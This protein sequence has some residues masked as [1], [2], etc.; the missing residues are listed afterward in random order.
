MA[1]GSSSSE[2]QNYANWWTYYRTRMNMMTTSM[3]LAFKSVDSRYR[4][5]YSTISTFSAAEGTNF[6]SIRD[7]DATQKQ[8]FYARLAAAS[9]GGNTP[10][11]GALSK[12]G[13]YFAKKANGQIAADDPMQYSCQRNFTILSTDGYWN[14]GLERTTAPKYGPYQLDNNTLVAQQDGGATL[15]PMFD[16]GSVSSTTTEKWDR[17][18]VTV[19]RTDTPKSN[20]TTVV[21]STTVQKPASSTAGQ[22]Q[23]ISVL[24]PEFSPSSLSRN[25]TTITVTTSAAHGL[26]CGDVIDVAGGDGKSNSNRYLA[27]NATVTV[28][29]ATQF[30]YQVTTA[31][32]S[33][34]GG[35]YTISPGGIDCA[36]G[37]SVQRQQTFVRDTVTVTTTNVS[38]IT[39]VNSTSSFTTTETDTTPLTRTVKTVNGVVI[40]DTTT[41]GAVSSG[42]QNSSTTV[43]T[44]P[45]I[46]EHKLNTPPTTQTTTTTD[47]VLVTTGTAGATCSASPAATTTKSGLASTTTTQTT[48]RT[49]NTPSTING[50][51]VVTTISSTTTDGT[52][53]T[54]TPAPVTSGG[55]Q[56]TL[57]DIAMYYYQT[58]LRDTSLG[59]CTGALGSDVCNNNVPGGKGDAAH[60]F[61]DNATWQHM[62]T[63]TLGLGA[64]GMLKYDAAYQSQLSGDFFDITNSSKNWPTPQETDNGGGPQN[65]DDL[66]HAAVDG[67][68]Q[69]FSA[70]NPSSLAVSLNSA[71]DKI[72]SVTG[73]ASAA[74][75]SSLQPVQGDNDIY[76]AQFTT[77]KWVGDVLAFTIDPNDGSIST[78]P[79]WSA[80]TRLDLLAPASRVIYYADPKGAAPLHLFTFTNLTTDGYSSLFNNFCSDSNKRGA[81]GGTAPAQCANLNTANLALANSGTNLVNYLRGD[82]TQGYYRQ[83]DNLLGDIINA[84]PLFVGKPAFKYSENNYQT[85]AASNAGRQAVVL[86]A[87]NDGM[88]HAFKR[89]TGDELWAFIPSF[90]MG[91]LYKLADTGY[92]NNH[93]YFVDGSPILGD[94]YTGTAWK[95]IVVGGL[96]DGGRGYYAL[97]VTDP[98]A[99]KLLWEYKNDNLGLSYGNPIITKRKDGT[100]VVVIG[101]GYNNVSP[102]TATATSSC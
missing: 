12:A 56:N 55:S 48:P 90:V 97:D 63:F 66:W 24:V 30:T 14:T 49:T 41:S 9:P 89:T 27:D 46:V 71:L 100:W 83:R 25:G 16:G 44:D 77:Q 43:T 86:A 59:N 40:S 93:S 72:K 4:V 69:Y 94:I 32:T 98:A 37:K 87:A 65:I 57:A 78:A 53:T 80:K 81:D 47:W 64:S 1:V 74:S 26:Q 99:P 8:K 91:N 76:V 34:A 61:G 7:F 29:S 54:S 101:S 21:T 18:V 28:I 11:R 31:P 96:N 68:G 39:T 15:R 92:S 5:G 38:D 102:A 6:L 85:F 22:S 79:T 2:S 88:L 50:T 20:V 19:T 58:D 62:T 73:A 13:Q 52:K 51:P 70:G 67:R 84:S 45:P 82:Q 42:S 95:T 35:T 36:S 23:T 33:G 60:S 17:K 10:L 3:T 75:T